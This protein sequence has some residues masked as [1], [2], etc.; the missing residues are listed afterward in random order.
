M[1]SRTLNTELHGDDY[2]DISPQDADRL[3]LAEPCRVR[4]VS[5]YGETELPVRRNP[6]MK[7]GELFATFHTTQVAL[8]RVTSS[9]RDHQVDTPEYKVTTV[10]IEKV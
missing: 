6:N 8:N 4:L 10:R 3:G 5:R 1:T 7:P 2:L 9:H